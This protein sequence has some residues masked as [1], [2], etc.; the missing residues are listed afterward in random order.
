MVFYC[1]VSLDGYA[2]QKSFW[3]RSRVKFLWATVPAIG[4]FSKKGLLTNA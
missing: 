4:W 3:H 1:S 2:M